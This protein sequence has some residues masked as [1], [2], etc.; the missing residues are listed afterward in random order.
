MAT[1]GLPVKLSFDIHT[2]NF[3][4]QFYPDKSRKNPSEIFVPPLHYP[5]KGYSVLTSENV[6]WTLSSNNENIILLYNGQNSSPDKIE[7]IRLI[8]K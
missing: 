8:P 7:F 5:K 4:F 2:K 3:E 1:A 6:K